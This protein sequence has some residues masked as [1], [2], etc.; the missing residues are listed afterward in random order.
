[1]YKKII[2]ITVLA[3]LGIGIYTGTNANSANDNNQTLADLLKVNVA[4]AECKINGSGPRG[5]C[6]G[7]IPGNETWGECFIHALGDQ[8]CIH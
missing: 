2:G 1:M 3:I 4:N 5:K 8:E 7:G 6:V